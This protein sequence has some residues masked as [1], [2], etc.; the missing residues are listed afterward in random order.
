MANIDF[1]WAPRESSTA[2]FTRIGASRFI[3]VQ[4]SVVDSP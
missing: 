4:P 2:G 3:R 1:D